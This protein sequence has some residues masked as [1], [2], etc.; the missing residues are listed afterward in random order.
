MSLRVLRRLRSFSSRLFLVFHRPRDGFVQCVLQGRHGIDNHGP[1]LC[2]E[3]GK[4]QVADF[5]CH[6]ADAVDDG[7]RPVP[8]PLRRS[9]G[10]SGLVGGDLGLL[11]PIQMISRQT[12]QLKAKLYYFLRIR[13]TYQAV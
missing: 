2:G 8:L 4:F 12:S 13:K 5:A 3:V 10:I 6:D 11:I 1:V 9:N 7:L